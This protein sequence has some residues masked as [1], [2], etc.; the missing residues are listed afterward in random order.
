M[1][2]FGPGKRLYE[3]GGFSLLEVIISTVMFLL[4]T[5]ILFGGYRT[6]MKCWRT[7][8][9]KSE[10]HR[11]F[12][13]IS[14]NMQ[15]ELSRTDIDTVLSGSTSG[16]SWLCFK[17]NTDGDG[18]PYYDMD[19][20][21][22]WQKY[23]LYYAIRPPGDR[24]ASPAGLED[25]ICPHKYI[26]RKDVDIS[27]DITG[28]SGVS[29]HLTF[30]LAIGQVT[31]ESGVLYVKPL[32]ED[33]FSFQGTRKEERVVMHLEILRLDEVSSHVAIGRNSLSGN[34]LKPYMHTFVWTII[35]KNYEP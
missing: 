18:K 32:C 26:I 29:P 2:G 17:S 6:F 9:S 25:D 16:K 28:E 19:G 30:T 27:D 10:I 1:R 35:P 31:S 13:R 34:D 8:E 15:V 11:K 3:T 5:T 22:Q 12:L 24:C 23:I 14:N 20:N 33:I 21:P 7:A 4:M